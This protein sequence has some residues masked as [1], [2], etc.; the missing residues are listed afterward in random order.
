MEVYRDED[1]GFWK[2]EASDE[3]WE[4]SPTTSKR[5]RPAVSGTRWA[6]IDADP[7]LALLPAHPEPEES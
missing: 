2:L 1:V 3:E 4:L 5:S 7:E 6:L